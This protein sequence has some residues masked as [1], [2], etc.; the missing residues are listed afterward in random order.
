VRFDILFRGLLLDNIASLALRASLFIGVLL[1]F[2]LTQTEI[3]L[4]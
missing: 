1:Q 4:T 2:D 3:G